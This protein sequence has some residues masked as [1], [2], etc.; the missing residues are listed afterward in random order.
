M[1]GVAGTMHEYKAGTLRSGSARGPKV[2]GRKQAL[3]IG[4]SQERKMKRESR[5]SARRS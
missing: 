5:R 1:P 2:T 3:A 4:L